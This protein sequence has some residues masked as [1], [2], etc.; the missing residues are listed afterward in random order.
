MEL[1]ILN[2]IGLLHSEF[3]DNFFVFITRLGDKGLI[4]IVLAGIL[5]I[6]KDTRKYGI[7]I[8]AVLL[9]NLI[10]GEGILKHLFNRARPFTVGEFN[11]LIEAPSTS[12]FPSGHTAS[13]FAVLGTFIFY[14]KKYVF[15]VGVL[16]VLI[17]FSRLYLQV[18]YLTDVLAGAILGLFVAYIITKYLVGKYQFFTKKVE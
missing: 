14:I 5:L 18:H 2:Y 15:P 4:W 12:S 7:M 17:S 8:G 13:S 3:L 9:V 16:A 11:L 6:K 1:E 10:I